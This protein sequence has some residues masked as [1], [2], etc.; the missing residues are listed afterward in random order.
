MSRW[1]TVANRI[2]RLYVSAKN[3]SG[4]LLCLVEYIM[5]VY[6]PTWFDI[7]VNSKV[8]DG[9]INQF[10]MICRVRS[11]TDSASKK[12]VYPVIKRNA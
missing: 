1:L 5:N 4:Q 8:K 11:L 9:P 2:L 6:T 3:P 10:K 12:I 7:K